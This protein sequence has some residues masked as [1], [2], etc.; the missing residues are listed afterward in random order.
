[1]ITY[2]VL[3]HSAT[4]RDNTSLNA[5]RRDH[6][7]R[8]GRVYYRYMI[9]GNGVVNKEHDEVN[10]RGKGKQSIDIMLTGNF[11]KESPS[12]VQLSSLNL[13]LKK[14]N[15]ISTIEA[16]IGHNDV[17]RYGV[18]GTASACPSGLLKHMGD[19]Q[20]NQKENKKGDILQLIKDLK[21]VIA[22]YE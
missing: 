20:R 22:K 10:R 19:F 14:I 17:A 12:E 3:H 7:K 18:W 2:I 11:T 6:K 5:I 4:S 21:E 16:T 13:L 9:S 1:M 8:Y 15:E